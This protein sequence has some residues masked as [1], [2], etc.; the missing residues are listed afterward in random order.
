MKK[1]LTLLTL[2]V[3]LAGLSAQTRQEVLASKLAEHDMLY[4]LAN[5]KLDL[6]E[7]KYKKVVKELN[8]FEWLYGKQSKAGEDI[9][10]TRKRNILRGDVWGIKDGVRHYQKGLEELKVIKQ[11]LT[12]LSNIE[13]ENIFNEK[14]KNVETKLELT[15]LRVRRTVL[16][17]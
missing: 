2:L 6:Y 13:D 3:V 7:N 16:G 5:E 12:E 10:I 15:D 1:L 14:L 17:W 8:K 11:S 4:E 9:S